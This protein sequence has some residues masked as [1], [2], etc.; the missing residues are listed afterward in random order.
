MKALLLKVQTLLIALLI[1][2]PMISG[3]QDVKSGVDKNFT[4]D[5]TSKT[6][7][8]TFTVD[9]DTK[10]LI[11]DF[12]GNISQ[13]TL[14]VDITDPYGNKITGFMLRTSGSTKE[15]RSTGKSYSY[16]EN[17]NSS[18]STRSS[19]SSRSRSTEVTETVKVTNDDVNTTEIN[20]I[21]NYIV[22]TENTESNSK[23]ARG[24][25]NKQIENPAEGVWEFTIRPNNASGKLSATIIYN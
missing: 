17:E 9:E 8:F 13:G 19:S 1:A 5:E 18:S 22:I 25:I 23:G 14:K 15:G 12:N 11:I 10:K 24:V 7:K 3:A 21:N 20:V 4:F 6:E 2:T 16:S